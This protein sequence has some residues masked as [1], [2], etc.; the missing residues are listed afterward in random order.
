MLD[1]KLSNADAVKAGSSKD[2]ALKHLNE[3]EAADWAATLK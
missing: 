2:V 1:L 3:R